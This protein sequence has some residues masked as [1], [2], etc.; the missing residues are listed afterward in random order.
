MSSAPPPLRRDDDGRHSGR[1]THVPDLARLLT[2]Y[3]ARQKAG[4]T[5]QRMHEG[6]PPQLD[7]D[8]PGRLVMIF[9]GRE[10]SGAS[11]SRWA[12][13]AFN[14]VV[15]SLMGAGKLL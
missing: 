12:A 9:A 4:P 6:D 10:E 3:E 8:E 2:M 11:P 7:G 14:R 15:A 13:G 5:A 1:G